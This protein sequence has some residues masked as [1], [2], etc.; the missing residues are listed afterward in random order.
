M[1]I[2]I[3]RSGSKSRTVQRPGRFVLALAILAQ[4]GAVGIGSAVAQT[5]STPA[6][7]LSSRSP[8]TC[9]PGLGYV[10]SGGDGS[11]QQVDLTTGVRSAIGTF[12]GIAPNLN[13]MDI[14]AGGLSA[15]ASSPPAASGGTQN[16]YKLDLTTNTTQTFAGAVQPS[17]VGPNLRGAINPVNGWYYYSSA[18]NS[19]SSQAVYAFDTVNN[20]SIG[21]VGTLTNPAYSGGS[22]DMAFDSAGN[23]YLLISGGTTS[24]L[25]RVNQTLPTTASNIPLTASLV[26]T[27]PPS[28]SGTAYGG[29][30]FG[31]D[32]YLYVTV[33]EGA[34][35]VLSKIDP[36]TGARVSSVNMSVPGGTPSGVADAGNC[37][38]TGSLTAQKNIVGRV[39]PGDQFQVAITGNG[40]GSGNTGTTTGTDTGL[41]TGVGER[42]TVPGVV[43]KTYTFTETGANGANLA[44]YTTTY[45]CVDTAHGNAPIASGNGTTAQVT[46][47]ASPDANGVQATC[48]FTNYPGV[49]TDLAL[50][51]TATPAAYTPGQPLTYK[52]TVSNNGPRD[53]TGYTVN[54]TLPAG[55]LNPSTTTPGCTITA[56]SLTCTGGPLANGDDDTITVTGTAADG[57]ADITNTATVTVKDPDPNPGNN[58]D[59]VKTPP[60]PAASADLAVKKTGPA[61]VKPG[62][63]ITYNIVITNNGPSGSTGWTLTDTIPAGVTGAAT[64]TPGCGIGA[65]TLTCTGGPLANGDSVTVTVTGKAPAGPATVKNTAKVTG[66]DPDPVPG[67][68]TSTTTTKVTG[69]PGLTIT[70][71]QN[72]PATVKAGATVK[73]TITVKNTGTTTY[74]ASAPASFSDDLSDLLD[75]ARYKNDAKATRGTVKYSNPV[76]KWSGALTPG[77]SATITFSI[78]TNARPFGDL[79]LLNTVVSNTPGN[80]CRPATTRAAADTRCSTKGKIKAKDKDK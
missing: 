31:A 45:S 79:K 42:T 47:P 44:D 11:V 20:V 50:T 65:G 16:V 60:A 22:G 27:L 77:Q 76:L 67:N 58:T 66:K 62:G 57:T 19:S 48:T 64:S 63:K 53:S 24:V 5:G 29:V 73:Y 56:G 32:G 26:S 18:L 4:L 74:T 28:A 78:T 43:G 55:L 75:D 33:N 49:A 10:L 8:A 39:N 69:T 6:S 36:N 59:T 61:T 2:T 13:A 7:V 54:D 38:F 1:T 17:G 3:D 71:K 34:A 35:G 51:K 37:S 46:Q 68:N 40:I 15:W 25:V 12:T 23:L 80:N 21:Q 30:L 9:L 70:K 52:I 14:A 41:Q 72:G